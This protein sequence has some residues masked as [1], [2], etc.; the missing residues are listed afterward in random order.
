MGLVAFAGETLAY[1]LTTDYEAAKL[2]WRDLLPAD[3]PVGGTDLGRAIRA[4]SEL[5]TRG[6]KAT[7]KRKGAQVLLLLTDGED[8]EGQGQAAAKDAAA[9]GIRIYTLGIGSSERPF[10]Q[11]TDSDGKSA[12]YLT[13]PD[14]EPLRV[15]L[16]E[17][18]LRQMAAATG[19]EYVALD[20]RRFGVE[21]VQQAIAGL[22]RTEE[23]ARFEREPDDVGRWFF[24]PA[25]ILLLIEAAIRERRQVRRKRAESAGAPVDLQRAAM[26]FLMLFP[27]VTGFD[28]FLRRDPN[29]EEGNKQLADG[30]AEDAL[31]AFDHAAGA[32]PDEPIVRFDRGTALYALGRFPEAQK[33]FMRAAEGHDTGLKADAYYNMGNSLMKQ[34]RY[35]DALDAYKHTLVVRPDDRRAK[36]NLEL[37]LRRM[38]E[39]EQ[40]KKQQ[41]Q[42]P[43]QKDQQQ[44]QKDQQQSQNDQQKQ[45]Q[46]KDQ[47][48]QKEQQQ[49]KD[50][51]QKEQQAK[52]EQEKQQQKKQPPQDEQQKKQ[53]AER[54]REAAAAKRE[55]PKDID[56]QDAEAVLDALERVEPTVQK[57]L[58]RR[59]AGNRRPV[60]DW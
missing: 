55:P 12:G 45:Q 5:L 2:F 10:V 37:A 46:Q 16:D 57:E 50:Q 33:E 60:K 58:A 22:E 20:A 51:Q 41:Q 19:G 8:T 44:Q 14:G 40:K 25:F 13:G 42:Q 15:G 17:A 56:K 6:K 35:K 38:R 54:E 32:L 49:Q 1:P 21:R 34:E 30:K 4:S 43:Q 48:Q 26:V 52:A 59:R 28:L 53:Q 7:D 24:L 36:W 23:E 9:L 27:F 29:V 11:L 39:E 31:K 3:M 18:A 47:Q